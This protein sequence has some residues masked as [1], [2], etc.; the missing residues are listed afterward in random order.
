MEISRRRGCL[1]DDLG[2]HCSPLPSPFPSLSGPKEKTK[3]YH[4]GRRQVVKKKCKYFFMVVYLF[5]LSRTVLKRDWELNRSLCFFC[6]FEGKKKRPYSSQCWVH[7]T[8]YFLLVLAYRVLTRMASSL[9]EGNIS[10]ELHHVFGAA[11]CQAFFRGGEQ[12]K[13]NPAL[14]CASQC[15]QQVNMGL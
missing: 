12:D 10:T 5:P 1:R 7:H 11:I 13:W 4:C 3:S 2:I 9:L 14:K 6:K 15:S 8:G